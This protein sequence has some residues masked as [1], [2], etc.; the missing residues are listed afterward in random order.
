MECRQRRAFGMRHRAPPCD[1]H[2]GVQHDEQEA[3]RDGREQ[4]EHDRGL[5]APVGGPLVGDADYD[6]AG[7]G[8]GYGCGEGEEAEPGEPAEEGGVPG[9][10]WGEGVLE[11]LRDDVEGGFFVHF[12]LNDFAK[13]L[14]IAGA[15]VSYIDRTPARKLHRFSSLEV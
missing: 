12:D 2:A 10:G 15:R 9:V 4:G 5:E 6:C 11:G 1:R 7:D 8:A 3:C 13:W 14:K